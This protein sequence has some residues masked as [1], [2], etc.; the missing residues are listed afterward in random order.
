MTGKSDF[1]PEEWEVVLEGPPS[2]GLIV[3]AAQRGGTFLYERG[4]FVPIGILTTEGVLFAPGLVT[5][6]NDA[7]DV[8]FSSKRRR[9]DLWSRADGQIAHVAK[10]GDSAPGVRRFRRFG[11]QLVLSDGGV[12]VFQANFQPLRTRPRMPHVLTG[13]FAGTGQ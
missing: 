6:L 7:G 1:T 8:L 9:I 4:T 2:G 12:V 13:I 10:N 3:V 11:R 5:D